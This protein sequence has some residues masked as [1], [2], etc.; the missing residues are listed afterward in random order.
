M[1]HGG[2]RPGA[3]RKPSDRPFHSEI[4]VA[5]R[6][7]ADKLPQLVD[8]MLRAALRGTEEVNED[9]YEEWVPIELVTKRDSEGADTPVYTP[10]SEGVNDKGEVCVKRTVKKTVRR[11]SGDVRAAQDLLDRIM[12]RAATEQDEA[13]EADQ[14]MTV[15][16]VYGE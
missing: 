2:A 14:V 6:R 1:T 12:G 8:A 7:A 13:G 11:R 10:E 4:Q 16:V 9:V 3:G 5:K 15:K